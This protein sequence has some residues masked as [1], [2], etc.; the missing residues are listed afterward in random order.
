MVARKGLRGISLARPTRGWGGGGDS[1]QEK[2]TG[3]ASTLRKP[4]FSVTDS[5][6]P[7]EGLCSR[8]IYP[9]PTQMS[10][11]DQLLE[12][13]AALNPRPLLRVPSSSTRAG[14]SSPYKLPSKPCTKAL[15]EDWPWPGPR[16]WKSLPHHV[17]R[18]PR[19]G[20]RGRLKV[21][22]PGSAADSQDHRSLSVVGKDGLTLTLIS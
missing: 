2:K 10:F 7:D 6:I 8:K 21:C 9:F 1:L 3:L 17:S 14:L 4:S 16:P 20:G 13:P 12:G 22:A 18:G 5:S 11:P 15:H 19:L